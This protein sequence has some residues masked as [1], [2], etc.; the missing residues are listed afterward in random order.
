MVVACAGIGAAKDF[1]AIADS[2]VVE[3]WTGQFLAIANPVVVLVAG[4]I[5]ST[6]A[7]R[8]LYCTRSVLLCGIDV[9]IA[10]IFIGASQEL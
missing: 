1:G 9:V 6:Y 4:A 2:V 10:G 8:I 7:N 3:V 5:A